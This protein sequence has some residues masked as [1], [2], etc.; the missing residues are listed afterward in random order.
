[1]SPPLRR[2]GTIVASAQRPSAAVSTLS[3]ISEAILKAGISDV[4]FVTNTLREGRVYGA[5][6]TLQINLHFLGIHCN[7]TQQFMGKYLTKCQERS[8]GHPVPVLTV[9]SQNSV[10][11][12]LVHAI[13]ANV[14]ASIADSPRNPS[15]RHCK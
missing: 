1:M 10:V 5:L 14:K 12:D 4:T 11:L 13:A 3:V 9:S 2:E 15:T 8:R 7:A 6:S